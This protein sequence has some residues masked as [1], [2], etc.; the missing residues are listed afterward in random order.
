MKSGQS[1]KK[2]QGF[3]LIEVL[4]SLA[5]FAIG[6]IACYALQVRSTSSLGRANSVAMSSTWAT[7]LIEDLISVDYEDVEDG[8]GTTDGINGLDD[9]APNTADGTRY[10]QPDGTVAN[11]AATDDLYSVYWNV[12][13]DTPLPDVKQIRVTVV[14]N[15]GLNAGVLYSHDYFKSNEN[16]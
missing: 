10:I 6:I 12:A 4:V 5:I 11:T 8:A 3:T 13:D 9:I 16:L 1:I 14:K 7:Y 15:G 2:Q